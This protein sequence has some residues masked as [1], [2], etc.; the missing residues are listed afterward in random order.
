MGHY[1]GL[2]SVRNRTDEERVPTGFSIVKLEWP[3]TS[4][5]IAAGAF[6]SLQGDVL[7]WADRQ[8]HIRDKAF[9]LRENATSRFDG[10]GAYYLFQDEDGRA[11]WTGY[12][13]GNPSYEQRV[14]TLY[15]DF[16]INLDIN[17]GQLTVLPPRFAPG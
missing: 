12:N 14:V 11:C 7:P 2:Y 1:T 13:G 3:T 5:F 15:S 6:E 4:V 8:Q 17:V 10:T 16:G 9:L